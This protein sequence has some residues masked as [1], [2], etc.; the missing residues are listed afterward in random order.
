MRIYYRTVII[1][2]ICITNLSVAGASNTNILN[3]KNDSARCILGD[4]Q[5]G[6]GKVVFDDNTIYEGE[7]LN[8]LANGYGICYYADGS[9]YTG[10]WNN[11]NI[12]GEGIYY[13]NNGNVIKGIWKNNE[14]IQET[15]EVLKEIYAFAD[16]ETSEELIEM[17]TNDSKTWVVIVGIARYPNKQSLNFTDDDAYRFHSFVKSPEGGAIADNQIKL[18]IDE[19]A[20][21]KNILSALKTIS[22]QATSEDNFIFYFSGH[23]IS[24]GFLPH[25]YADRTTILEHQ[26]VMDILSESAAKSKIV[27]ADACHSGSMIKHK[28]VKEEAVIENYYNAIAK[29]EGG[30]ILFMSSKEEETSLE[31]K[32]LRQGVF[33]YYLLQGLKGAAD[34]DSDK[35]ICTKELFDYVKIKVSIY[36][37]YF[38]TPVIYGEHTVNVPLGAVRD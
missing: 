36:T 9:T 17:T 34:A 13:I 24:G 26:E 21:K 7:F 37:N 1:I 12:E 33:S 38:Q 8:G 29:S 28:G 31:N 20:T 3:L 5:N 11:N 23:G 16:F 35:I 27:I 14:L 6:K 19:T 18:L 30:L 25:D 32:G 15:N 10:Y 2:L 22:S 4:C